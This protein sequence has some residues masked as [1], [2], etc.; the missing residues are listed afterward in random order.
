MFIYPIATNE[1]MSQLRRRQS[2]QINQY[3][4][5]RKRNDARPE[6]Q[7]AIEDIDSMRDA[8]QKGNHYSNFALFY[9]VRNDRRSTTLTHTLESALGGMLIILN[10]RFCRWNKDLIPLP[11]R[12]DELRIMRNM[13]TG[14]CRPLFRLPHNTIE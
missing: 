9:L 14:S 3:D 8:L 2:Q 13:D 12:T 1:V 11:L 6:L 4:A 5:T 7:T 10:N